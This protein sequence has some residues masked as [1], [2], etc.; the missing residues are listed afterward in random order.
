[1]DHNLKF[2]PF[3]SDVIQ[4]FVCV[5][6]LCSLQSASIDCDVVCSNDG[7]PVAKAMNQFSGKTHNNRNSL[8]KIKLKEAFHLC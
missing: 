3:N 1:M 2:R 5:I 4:I 8:C 7:P 6:N